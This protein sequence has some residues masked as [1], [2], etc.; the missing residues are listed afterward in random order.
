MEPSYKR[1][2]W[3]LQ[4]QTFISCVQT[5][6]KVDPGCLLYSWKSKKTSTVEINAAPTDSFCK[7]RRCY[8]YSVSATAWRL[9]V[10]KKK[11]WILKNKQS[12][13]KWWKCYRRRLLSGWTSLK[14]GRIHAYSGIKS[15]IDM[16]GLFLWP[17]HVTDDRLSRLDCGRT[18]FAGR[19]WNR[20]GVNAPKHSSFH[21]ETQPQSSFWL[22]YCC[23][24]CVVSMSSAVR[25][26]SFWP[27]SNCVEGLKEGL[28]N[29]TRQIILNK[30]FFL[31]FLTFHVF[32]FCFRTL[33][34]ILVSVFFPFFFSLLTMY[35][36]SNC[37]CVILRE[38]TVQLTGHKTQSLNNVS[39]RGNRIFNI[40]NNLSACCTHKS[41][42]LLSQ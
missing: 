40:H 41:E 29:M 5:C 1:E 2:L 12:F 22:C 16:A 30:P 39:K 17:C 3:I 36:L 27:E 35:G 15:C 31:F 19:L 42:Y 14:V 32:G 38:V 10:K 24:L 8:Y 23:R 21:F 4:R 13:L 11:M 34:V 18:F 25:P 20:M 26:F 33:A 37:H 28:F 9:L 7:Q 6:Q